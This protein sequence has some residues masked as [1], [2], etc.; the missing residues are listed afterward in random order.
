[1]VSRRPGVAA[2]GVTS[3]GEAG[4]ESPPAGASDAPAGSWEAGAGRPA[5]GTIAARCGADVMLGAIE[6][7]DTIEPG[8]GVNKP[9]AEPVEREPPTGAIT[10]PTGPVTGAST[11]VR[12]LDTGAST[13]PITGASVFV[14]GASVCV[15]GAS[16]GP[17]TG[18]SVC[19]TG[20]S[21]CVTG[22]S[23]PVTGAVTGAST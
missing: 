4:T 2:R 11:R 8:A 16:T 23:R 15:T 20:A 7:S 13:G 14:T 9:G 5:G 3:V 10:L 19:V 21:V 1:M 17:I 12:S 6:A 22:A 18:A